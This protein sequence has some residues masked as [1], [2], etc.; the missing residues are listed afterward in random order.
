LQTSIFVRQIQ[1]VPSGPSEKFSMDLSSPRFYYSLSAGYGGSATEGSFELSDI[2]IFNVKVNK[3][4][5]DIFINDKK[6]GNVTQIN[7]AEALIVEDFLEL[8]FSKSTNSVN[9]QVAVAKDSSSLS[10]KGEPDIMGK[11]KQLKELL[12]MEAITQEEFDNKKKDLLS[13]L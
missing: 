8:I 11:I 3:M 9:E 1:A 13:R 6:L 7:R 12:D 2:H 5:S 4:S 10:S